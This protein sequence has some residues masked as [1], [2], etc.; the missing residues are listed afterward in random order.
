MSK[1]VDEN[2]VEQVNVDPNTNSNTTDDPNV[3]EIA[4]L[5]ASDDPTLQQLA[6]DLK[7]E[8]DGENN[9]QTKPDTTKAAEQPPPAQQQDASSQ[10]PPPV[11]EKKNLMI[12]KGRFDEVAR[13]RDEARTTAAYYKGV[14]EAQASMISTATQGKAADAAPATQT[15]QKTIEQQFDDIDAKRIEIA[16]QYENGD[17]S[18]TEWEKQKV[19]LAKQERALNNQVAEARVKSVAPQ[20]QTTQQDDALYMDEKLVALEQAHPYTLEITSEADWLWLNKKATEQLT[21]E[22]VTLKANDQRS[23]LILRTRIAELTD[24]YGQML[25]GKVI[26]IPGKTQAKTTDQAKATAQQRQDKFNLSQQQP[27]A[28]SRMGASGAGQG[29]V[30]EADIEKMSDDEIAALPQSVQNRILGIT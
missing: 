24:T 13:E 30:T 12:P 15:Q 9:T 14:A 16:E 6:A 19:A 1:E 20:Q 11:G 21:A 10:E 28:V 17:I 23:N 3:A 25:T 27:P 18:A 29:E 2:P 5:E 4:A 8:R 22:G 7:A 26:N